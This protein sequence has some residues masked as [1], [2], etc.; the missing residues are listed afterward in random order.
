VRLVSALLGDGIAPVTGSSPLSVRRDKEIWLG[1]AAP[2]ASPHGGNCRRGGGGRVEAAGQAGAQ[3]PRPQT[4][5]AEEGFAESFRR[6]RRPRHVADRRRT[7]SDSVW[8]SPN[9]SAA[10]L[11]G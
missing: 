7:A 9:I 8:V 10:A 5:E 6:E 3:E 11:A 1:R 2:A 4:V